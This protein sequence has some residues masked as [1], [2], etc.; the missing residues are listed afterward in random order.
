MVADTALKQ[1]ENEDMSSQN[2][3]TEQPAGYEPADNPLYRWKS[4]T[5]DGPIN[6]LSLL[7]RSL[8]FAELAWVAYMAEDSAATIVD[9][10]G[11]RETLFFDR[12]GAQAYVF[13]TDHDCIVAC[14]GT[15]PNEW[16]DVK[17]DVN[18]FPEI[19]ETVGKVHRG[20]KKEVDDL[21]PRLEEALVS[22][23]KTLWFCGHS[24]GGA[25]ATI[26]SGRCFLSHI[27]STP[28]QLFTF[29][30]PRVGNKKYVNHVKLEHLRWVNNNDIVTRVPMAWMGYRHTGTLMYLN[31]YGKL[32]PLS[33]PQRAKDRWRGFWM[34]VKKGQVDHFADHSMDEYIRHINGA[35]REEAEGTLHPDVLPVDLT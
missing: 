12:H 22:N 21:W 35:L 6:E 28:R 24:L 30:S 20:F 4:N 13:K 33:A 10:I 8:L 9:D 26:C 1:S 7:Q 19:S 3:E 15:E 11:L 5:I 17:A 32:R 18:A 29:G 31:A 23:D 34:G 16:N 2:Q 27:P 14:R 25:M